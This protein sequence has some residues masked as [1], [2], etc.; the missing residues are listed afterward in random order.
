MAVEKHHRH[1]EEM[2]DALAKKLLRM[3]GLVEEAIARSVKALVDRDSA[4]AMQVIQEDLEVDRIE[5]EID[6][7]C[8]ETLAL[9]QPMARDLRFITTAMKIVTDLERI[10]DL[11][12]NVAERVLELNR[13]PQ[14]KPYIDIPLMGRRAQEMVHGALDAFVR[15]DSE[16]A[17]A[18]IGMDDD[19]DR[20]MEQIFREL[21]SFMV[22]DRKTITRALR[23]SI[24]SKCF[25]RIGDQATNICEQVVYMTEARVIKHPALTRPDAADRDEGAEE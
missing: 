5:L 11:A 12:G 8:M 19:L 15:R 23:L 17:R 25:E 3:G 13:E 14:L 1:F 4:L 20:R 22:E 21:V 10:G 16:L 9:Q 18:V 6:H 2:L 24:V 7:L